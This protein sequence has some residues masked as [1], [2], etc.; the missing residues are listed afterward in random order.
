MPQKPTYEASDF[1]YL[2]DQINGSLGG[3]TLVAADD[4]RLR[5]DDDSLCC[6]NLRMSP[7]GL[8]IPLI[9][10]KLLYLT[11]SLLPQPWKL[12]LSTDGTYRLLFDQYALLTVGVNVKNYSMRRELKMQAFRSSF[13]PLAFA[14][15][16]VEDGEAYTHFLQTCVQVANTLGMAV[17]ASHILQFHGDTSTRASKRPG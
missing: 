17:E 11:L 14:L 10:P 13:M 7:A 6:I 2:R 12:K 9:S 1:E 3:N 16:N 4:P 8:C 5:P 15:A